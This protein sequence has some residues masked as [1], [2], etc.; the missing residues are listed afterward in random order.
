MSGSDQP[1][2]EL[3][4]HPLGGSNPV[5]EAFGKY[6]SRLAA[7]PIMPGWAMPPSI[8]TLPGFLFGQHGQRQPNP[9]GSLAGRLRMTVRLGIDSLNAGL[10]S[11]A[12]ALGGD[13]TTP[14]WGGG[15]GGGCGCGGE[16]CGYDCCEVMGSD[17]CRPGAHGC[18]CGCC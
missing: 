11:G 3:S 1:A 4:D 12:S 14:H 15:H 5:Q 13:M 18:G 16:P 7:M 17:C 6:K 2:E 10:A 9:V 8:G